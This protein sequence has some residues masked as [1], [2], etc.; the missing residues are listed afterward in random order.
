MGDIVWGCYDARRMRDLMAEVGQHLTGRRVTVRARRSFMKHA[1]GSAHYS[2]DGSAVVDVD[3]DL[4]QRDAY[5]VYL[6]ELSHVRWDFPTHPI[7]TN[8]LLAPGV[9]EPDFD[10]IKGA[11][12]RAHEA[13]MDDQ[14]ER[15]DAWA[16]ANLH[17]VVY[18]SGD[19][20]I[21]KL[22]ALKLMTVYRK[23]SN[24]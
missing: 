1:R 2:P 15:W 16:E 4:S 11:A 13:A 24:E 18:P 19:R 10:E 23:G 6:H 14:A 5:E 9:V 12:Y 20:V 3:P 17:R 21:D 22:Q 7:G 8:A